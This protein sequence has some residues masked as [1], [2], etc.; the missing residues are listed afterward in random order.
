MVSSLLLL[1]C[2]LAPGQA[3]SSVVPVDRA[4]WFIRPQLPVGQELHY[5][6]SFKE[7]ATGTIQYRR[8]YRLETRILILEEPRPVIPLAVF[9]MVR[10][11]NNGPGAEA[12]P[13]NSGPVTSVRLERG[14]LGEHGLFKPDPGV[15]L[16]VPLDGPPSVEVGMFLELPR[17]RLSMNQTW[18]SAEL[19]RPIRSW[20]VAGTDL[21]YG[22]TCI[23]IVGEQK[24]ED[25][26]QPRLD[27]YAWRRLDTVWLAPRVGLAYKVERVIEKRGPGREEP[28][29]RSVLRYD[30]ESS[31]LCSGQTFEDRCQEVKQAL[32]FAATAQPLLPE[33]T[34]N[35]PQLKALANKIAFHLD[36]EPPTPYRE[37]VEQVRRLVE[38]GKR[39]EVPV[40]LPAETP[41]VP[42]VAALGEP[43]P[44]FVAPEVGTRG[45]TNLKR[46]LGKPVLLVFFSP[47]SETADQLLEFAQRVA[48]AYPEQVTVLGM[49]MSDDHELVR[50]RTARLLLTFPLFNGTCLRRCYAIEA[51]PKM[52]L[53]DG[54]GVVRGAYLGWG[55]EIPLDVVEEL[56]RWLPKK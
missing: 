37:A 32:A 28:T 12:N 1:G 49:A 51:T 54:A 19:G 17:D 44:D 8:D 39:G 3:P 36:R 30:L 16:T 9:T 21:A 55:N 50:E 52:V 31:V 53:L 26:D 25:W 47:T 27:R 5:V 22:T 23:K 20:R 38:A 13:G 24:S 34:R 18:T 33:P 15:G 14:F 45:S 29:Q 11:Q 10:S 41:S 6:G 4:D 42:G 48:R 46:W 40:T 7:E 2:V 35:L 56:K 43:A